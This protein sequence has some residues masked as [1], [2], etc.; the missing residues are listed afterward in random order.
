MNEIVIRVWI[1][2]LSS[3]L[4]IFVSLF[5]LFLVFGAWG[6]NLFLHREWVPI[7]DQIF[8]WLLSPDLNTNYMTFARFP[9]ALLG[10][11]GIFVVGTLSAHRLLRPED[12]LWLKRFTSI[13]FGLGE[14]G[15]VVIWLAAFSWLSF[16]RLS[17]ALLLLAALLCWDWDEMSFSQ[18]LLSA[19]ASF[20]IWYISRKDFKTGT[21][22]LAVISSA[23]FVVM[24]FHAL[25][26]PE[27]DWDATVYHATMAKLMFQFGGVPLIAGPSIGLELSANYPP[28]FSALGSYFYTV[29][30]AFDDTYLRMIPPLCAILVSYTTYKLGLV[31]GGKLHGFIATLLLYLTPLFFYRALSAT[32]YMLVVTFLNYSLLFL[33]LAYRK[34]HVRY[35]LVSG[36]AYGFA[37][38]TSYHALFFLPS[39][40]LV[41]GFILWKNLVARRRGALRG[42]LVAL[43]AALGVGCIWFARNLIVV[44]NPIY[45]FGY[46]LFKGKYLDPEMLHRTVAGVR[47]DSL[48]AFWGTDSITPKKYLVGIFGNSVHFPSLSVISLMGIALVAFLEKRQLWMIVILYTIFPFAIVLSTVANIFPRYILL[49]LPQLALIS[50]VV[51]VVCLYAVMDIPIV[52]GIGGRMV[53]LSFPLRSL[54]YS[55]VGVFFALTLLFPALFAIVGGKGF[56]E[57]DWNNPPENILRFVEPTQVASGNMLELAYSDEVRAW[58]WINSSLLSDAKVATY[59]N[60]VYYIAGSRPDAFFYLDGWEARN[61]YDIS[62]PDGMLRALR[63]ENVQY[64]LDPLWI[65]HWEMYDA[66][67]LNDYLGWPGY[68]PLVFS[69]PSTKVYQV[70]RIDDPVTKYSSVPVSLSPNGWSDIHFMRGRVVRQVTQGDVEARIYIGITSPVI[71]TITYLDQGVG[72]VTFNLLTPHNEWD[73]DFR[74]IKLQDTGEWRTSVFVLAT[75]E[76][77]GLAELGV[78]SA[79]ND[80]VVAGI[81]AKH[82][83]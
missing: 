55:A 21:F 73:Y 43:L 7:L 44:G 64:I 61:L 33:I 39:I 79:E 28:L 38:L 10:W 16:R 34:N 74:S 26:F 75:K 82:L 6:G 9:I 19:K 51:F 14:I 48:F 23:Y 20:R 66:L 35:W 5:L 30:G 58:D 17:F 68:F 40:V 63:L 3:L 2:A 53:H 1:P 62:D 57:A 4:R 45:P 50:A 67:P 8:S 36:V 71:V 77:A 32:N 18:M 29:I 49:F 13:V 70:G 76:T 22:L 25:S 15:S 81:E 47:R 56:D 24:Q 72:Q 83:K 65:R 37:L 27:F 80:F 59:E 54:V 31:I 46:S 69:T 78:Y 60:R 11:G 42:A 41:V 52:V 12:G